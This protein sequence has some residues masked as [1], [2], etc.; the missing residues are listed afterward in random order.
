[1]TTEGGHISAMTDNDCQNDFTL[2][3]T[4]IACTNNSAA[5]YRDGIDN[6]HWVKYAY[7]DRYHVPTYNEAT[8]SLSEQANNLI[9]N[10]C[11]NPKPLEAFKCIF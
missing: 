11:R 9:G 4:E 10:K 6:V 1:M 5:E 7:L 8:P 2:H 3:N